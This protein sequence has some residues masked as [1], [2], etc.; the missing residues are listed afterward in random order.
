MSIKKLIWVLLLF[1]AFAWGSEHC[2]DQMKGVCR[3]ICG[4]SEVSETGAFI[5]CSEGQKCCVA[6][7]SGKNSAPLSKVILIEDYS[8]SP[9]EIRIAKGTEVIWKNNDGV[10][11]TVT[12]T[13][14]SFDSG[15]LGPDGVYK[16]RFDK[17]GTYSYACDMHPG[18]SGSIVVE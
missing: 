17:A 3:E 18:M 5:D 14:G 12:G 16:K 10:E 15:T 2:V 6:S 13:D 9:A 8:F 11:H 4:Q 7:A 1:P